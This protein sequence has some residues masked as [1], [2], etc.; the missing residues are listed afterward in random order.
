MGGMITFALNVAQFAVGVVAGA[1]CLY[2]SFAYGL[3]PTNHRGETNFRGWIVA[4]FSVAV[5]FVAMAVFKSAAQP[6][7]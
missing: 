7:S 5:G 3:I 6:N 2:L 4:F 1:A